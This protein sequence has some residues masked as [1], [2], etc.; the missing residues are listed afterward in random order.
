MLLAHTVDENQF[1]Y[2]L[3]GIAKRV[4]GAK[5]VAEEDDLKQ[6]VKHLGGSWTNENKEMF[7]ATPETLGKYCIADCILTL[8][9]KDYFEPKLAAQDLTR[10]FYDDETMPLYRHFTIPAERNGIRLDMDLL[11]KAQSDIA[12]DIAKLQAQI[13]S[14]IQPSLSVW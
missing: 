5:A 1:D 13:L 12:I 14:E 6:E 4:F 7:K 9:L 8:R 3:K 2:K 11:Q 10:F